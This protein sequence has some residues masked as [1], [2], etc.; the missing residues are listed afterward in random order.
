MATTT[1]GDLLD[2]ATRL[3]RELRDIHP[4]ITVDQWETFD[5]TFHRVLHEIIGTDAH[6]VPAHD[7]D[8]RLLKETARAY[9]TPLRPPADEY[10][11][12]SQVSRLTGTH[13]RKVYRDVH[14]GQLHAV[15]ESGHHFVRT[16][17]LDR[18]PDIHP[19][20]PT[21]P[22]PLARLSVTLGVLADLLH[23]AHTQEAPFLS[24][25]GETGPAVT[26]VVSLGMVAAAAALD[27]MPHRDADRPF[28][29]AQWG[30]HVLAGLGARHD[31]ARPVDLAHITA[32]APTRTDTVSG[33]LHDA[34][35]DWRHAIDD[36]LGAAVPNSDTLRVLA[37]QSAHLV[38]VTLTIRD[39]SPHPT[40]SLLTDALRDAGL[41]LR[42]AARPWQHL[43]TLN[44]PSHA[45]IQASKRL[46]LTLEHAVAVLPNLDPDELRAA[47]AEAHRG[48][49]QTAALMDQTVTL[50]E[51]LARSGL[52]FA[53]ARRVAHNP[54]HLAAINRGGYVPIQLHDAPDLDPI[55]RRAVSS[56][57]WVVVA[58]RPAVPA[59]DGIHHEPIAIGR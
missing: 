39:A 50:P 9:P 12:P 29:V 40:S 45:F 34:I 37:Q 54:A 10:L 31:H 28:K 15:H 19:A 18:R 58:Q 7:P 24:G 26:H 35:Y 4:T 43:T 46:A 42:D 2:R 3:T 23:D 5:I 20:D 13:V 16:P 56:L 55:W 6:H 27:A 53:P 30:E 14:D 33:R 51:R 25:R 38:A 44:Q 57:D 41:N 48:I 11:S 17:Q 32:D 36:E 52:L 49:H 47:A 22:H 8:T 1:A 21:D 59:R